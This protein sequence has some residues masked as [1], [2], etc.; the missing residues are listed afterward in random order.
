MNSS[1][2]ITA[3]VALLG[4][5]SGQVMADP[6]PSWNDNNSRTAIIQF[7]ES[8]SDPALNAIRWLSNTDSS[9]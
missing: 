1:R 4:L 2:V 8:V 9:A 5:A 7:V 6:L 3:A